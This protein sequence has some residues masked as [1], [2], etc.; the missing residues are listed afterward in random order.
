MR[1]QSYYGPLVKSQ[2]NACQYRRSDLKNRK[3]YSFKCN[4]YRKYPLCSYEIHIIV[5]DY[6]PSLVTIM[7]R[8]THEHHQKERNP[9]TRLPSPLRQTVSKYVL[10]GLSQSQIKLSLVQDYPNSPIHY[11]KLVNLIN[12]ERRKNRRKLFFI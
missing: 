9:T 8:N 7:S 11:T 5:P 1:K 12:Y 4:E 3:K 10:C 6:D 2:F